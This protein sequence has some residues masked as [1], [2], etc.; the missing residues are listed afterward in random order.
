MDKQALE[1]A[2]RAILEQGLEGP[3]V[4][5]RDL[6]TIFLEES[7]RLDTGDPAQQAYTRDLFTLEESPRLGAGLMEVRGS[8]FPWELGYDEVDYVIDGHLTVVCGD[9]RA[10]AGPGQV[11][12]LPKGSRIR[13]QADYA[14]FLYVTYPANWQG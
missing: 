10:E 14:R 12:L 13:F 5:A 2:V 11:L 1:Q 7:D 4:L 8:D 3:R 6:H 9:R